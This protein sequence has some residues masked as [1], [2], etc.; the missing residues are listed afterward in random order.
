MYT[1][2]APLG[3]VAF[4]TETYDLLNSACYL[5]AEATTAPL[6]IAEQLAA[7]AQWYEGIACTL[8]EIRSLPCCG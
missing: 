5:W 1:D 8:D 2:H 7:S 6:D 4:R 3:E